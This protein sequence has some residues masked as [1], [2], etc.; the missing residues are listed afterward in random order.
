MKSYDELIAISKGIS[1]EVVTSMMLNNL[2]MVT[3]KQTKSKEWFRYRAGRITA[4]RYRQV[5]HTQISKP[6]Y[7]LLKAVCYPESA[8]SDLLLQN[9][10]DAIARYRSLLTS[11]DDVSI[12]KCGFHISSKYPFIGASP[13]A[14]VQCNC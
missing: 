7:S 11:H 6:S 8:L 5:L 9:E 12:T 13:D 3:R 2:E 10:N 14:L 4:S 1:H